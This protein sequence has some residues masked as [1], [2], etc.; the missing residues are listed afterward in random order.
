MIRFGVVGTGWRTE[1]FLRVARARPDLFT[2]VGVVTRDVQ[3]ATLWAEPFGVPLFESLD[4]LLA[5]KPLFVVTSIP[6][7]VNAEVMAYL[8]KRGMPVLSETPPAATID[9]MDQL[10]QRVKQGAKI[11]VAEQYHLQPHHQARLTFAHSGKIGTVTQAQVSVAHG[12]HGTSLIR[13]FLGLTYENATIRAQKF[14][15][16]IVLG[17]DR[18]G[19]PDAETIVNSEQVIATLDFEGKLGVFDFTSDQ[20]RSLIRDPR[21]LIRGERG[22]IVN[23][24]AVYLQD[25]LT[26]IHITFERRETGIQSNMGGKYLEGIQAGESWI[27]KN[28]LAPAPLFDDEI[29]VGVCLLKMAE[30]AEGGD[31]FYPLAEACQD[32]YLDLMIQQAVATGQPVRTTTQ[33][34]AQ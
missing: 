14:V 20:Y 12:Y 5:Q 21:L 3:K 16:P 9:E 11:A 13:R 23:N 32:H 26:S 29:A 18:A 8:T 7:T 10:Y 1:F 22:E 34:W 33:S 15:S 19:P 6:R 28:P 30:Y 17:A 24:S 27:Y 25:Y 2:A 4:D 31:A